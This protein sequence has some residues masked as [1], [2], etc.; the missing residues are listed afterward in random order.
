MYIILSICIL[1]SILAG[2]GTTTNIIDDTKGNEIE[3]IVAP[4]IEPKIDDT[5]KIVMPHDADYYLG[6]GKLSRKV[7]AELEELGFTNIKAIE[8]EEGIYSFAVV[9]VKIF[10]NTEDTGG[11]FNAGD[12]FPVDALV[13]VHYYGGGTMEDGMI[14]DTNAKDIEASLKAVVEYNWWEDHCLIQSNIND[15]WSVSCSNNEYNTYDKSYTLYAYEN[16]EVEYAKFET[17]DYDYDYLLFC[18]SL[19]ETSL[20][21]INQVQQWIK[22]YNIDY[23][24]VEKQF[25]DAVFAMNYEKF[26]DGSSSISLVI[27]ACGEN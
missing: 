15:E 8:E 14:Q 9:G 22:E 2:C 17:Y 19:F 27:T 3:E 5:P 12:A 4:T 21:D 16:L 11:S 18:A 26:N 10:E 25:G 1:V 6:S 23:D 7:V 13:E 20:I 24:W